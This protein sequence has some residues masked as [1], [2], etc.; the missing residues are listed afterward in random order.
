MFVLMLYVVILNGIT[1][2]S[3]NSNSSNMG[4][5]QT[6]LLFH[7]RDFYLESWQIPWK[8]EQADGEIEHFDYR[9][10]HQ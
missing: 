4:T 8:W 7:W 6:C 10:N 5:W 3:S 2:S 1:N 9:P